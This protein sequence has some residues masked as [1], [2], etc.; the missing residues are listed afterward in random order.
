MT[1]VQRHWLFAAWCVVVSL[2]A[3]PFLRRFVAFAWVDETAS[4]VLLVPLVTFALL[5]IERR[6]V[7]AA[8][9][10]DWVLAAGMLVAAGLLGVVARRAASPA[11]CLSL[12]AAAV[13]FSLL[14]GFAGCYGLSAMRAAA[15]PLAFLLFTVPVPEPLLNAAIAF[16]QKWSAEATQVLFTVTGTTFHREGNVFTLPDLVIEVAKECS[17]IRSSAGLLL[18]TLLAG[19]I[20]LRSAWT[21]ALLA[22]AVIP[23]TVLKNAIR[24]VSLSLLS[25]HVDRGFMEGWLHR[26][27]GIVFLVIAM[28]LLLPVLTLLSRLERAPGVGDAA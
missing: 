3:A 27:G 8:V 28:G 4:Y 14:A 22:L 13:V 11:D 17:G 7:F 15:F 10:S 19:H 12:G 9:G 25:I 18:T 20:A 16:L 26:S 2:V 23:V 6:S 5:V 21:K 24:I 1:L